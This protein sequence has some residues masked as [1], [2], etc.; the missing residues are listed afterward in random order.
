MTE[1]FRGSWKVSALF[2]HT[3]L[4]LAS[5][6]SSLLSRLSSLLQTVREDAVGYTVG[7]R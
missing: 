6:L 2:T 7:L 3:H 4:C 1:C 5:C